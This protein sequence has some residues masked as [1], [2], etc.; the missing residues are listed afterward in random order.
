[1]AIW[2]DRTARRIPPDPTGVRI[3]EDRPIKWATDDDLIR[4]LA[5]R[6]VV[7]VVT[8]MGR[9]DANPRNVPIKIRWHGPRKEVKMLAKYTSEVVAQASTKQD[10]END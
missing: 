1:M 6:N 10:E 3:R 7:C 2:I 4:E 5:M 9:L 8:V